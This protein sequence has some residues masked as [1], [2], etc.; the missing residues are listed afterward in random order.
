MIYLNSKAWN[1]AFLA[2]ISISSLM[3]AKLAS[4][5]YCAVV[6]KRAKQNQVI[7]VVFLLALGLWGGPLGW[8]MGDVPPQ[9]GEG[10]ERVRK[11]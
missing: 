3:S 10:V 11:I 6:Q 2:E 5:D 9:Q 1:A 4:W 8:R 7:S